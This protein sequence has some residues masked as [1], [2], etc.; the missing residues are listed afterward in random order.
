MTRSSRLEVVEQVIS[1][2]RCELHAQCSAPVPM[3]GEPGTWVAVG[4]APGE[5]EDREGRPFIGP[6]GKLLQDLLDEFD[7]PAPAVVNTVSCYPHGTPTWDHMKACET[8]KWAQID[9]L[10]PAFVLLLG[11]VALKGMRPDLDL[12][13]G[14]TRP[15]KVRGRVCFATYHPAAALRNGTFERGMRS[16]LEI[17]RELIDSGRDGWMKF[18]P[19]SCSACPLGADWFE[20]EAGLGWC[21]VHLPSSERPAYEARSALL[22]ADL[23]AAR[24][25]ALAAR[26]AGMTAVA[27]AA[28]PDWMSAAWDALVLWLRTHDEFFVDDFWAGSGLQEPRE[29]RALGPIVQRAARQGLMEKTGEFRKSVRSNMTEKPCWKSLIRP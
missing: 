2:T 12:K 10:D 11:R 13:R 3:R 4:E 26:D 22:A 27:D 25:R 20:A 14:R 21:P 16:D 9:Y 18:I 24:A 7:F 1:C 5:T 28:D 17:F 29:S 19:H 23:D 15:F 8:N 6:A